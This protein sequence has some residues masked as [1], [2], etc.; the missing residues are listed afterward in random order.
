MKLRE[1]FERKHVH[2][3]RLVRDEKDL[4]T[5][6]RYVTRECDSP[7]CRARAK[8]FLDHQHPAYE[9]PDSVVHIA[10]CEWQP[11]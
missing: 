2:A 9:T 10:D 1:P 11:Q 6:W 7:E 8:A 4:V 3:W 5:R